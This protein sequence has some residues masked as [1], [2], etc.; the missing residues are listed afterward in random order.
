MWPSLRS[1][2]GTGG[3]GTALLPA[4][5][6]AAGSGDTQL[7]VSK[8]KPALAL[9]STA[10]LEEIMESWNGLVWKGP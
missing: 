7:T 1:G 10:G 9:G 2:L 8:G 5:A 3:A 4:V 6:V